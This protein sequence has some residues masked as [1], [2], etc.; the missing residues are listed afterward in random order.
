MILWMYMLFSPVWI[1][2]YHCGA[3]ADPDKIHS[4]VWLFNAINIATC[5]QSW[6]HHPSVSGWVGPDRAANGPDLE[7]SQTYISICV[8]YI[9]SLYAKYHF[10]AMKP[11]KKYLY[12]NSS[13]GSQ[14]Y[15]TKNLIILTSCPDIM[16]TGLNNG[17]FG[18]FAS[19][20]MKY[21]VKNGLDD[22][23]KK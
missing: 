16:S 3:S 14:L 23:P 10:Q 4:H 9:F 1:T 21:H 15:K 11:H 22:G 12:T 7:S 17:C 2:M 5:T 19:I 18:C 6:P 8:L 13:S 20:L